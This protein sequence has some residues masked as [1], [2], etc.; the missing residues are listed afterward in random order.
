MESSPK[1]NLPL[2][3]LPNDIDPKTGTPF[4]ENCDACNYGGH[5]CPGCGEDLDHFSRM[6]DGSEHPDCTA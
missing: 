4:Y 1:A 5:T 2:S 6:L 3:A